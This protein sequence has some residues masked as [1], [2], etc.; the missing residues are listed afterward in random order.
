MDSDTD[1]EAAADLAARSDSGQATGYGSRP[2]NGLTYSMPPT[3]SRAH[4][5]AIREVRRHWGYPN[6]VDPALLKDIER[7]I[8][9]MLSEGPVNA[10]GT[11]SFQ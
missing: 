9:C 11:G 7:Y 8:A 2:D 3:L 1:K 5:D 4:L 10:G 6:L